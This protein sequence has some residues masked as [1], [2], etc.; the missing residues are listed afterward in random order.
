ML[1][2]G[3]LATDP[4]AAEDERAGREPAASLSA[5]EFHAARKIVDTPFG[6]I[7]YV[8]MGEGPVALFVHGALLNGYQWRHQLA[9][10]SDIRR[11]VAVDSMAMGYTEMAPGTPLGM[12]QQARMLA[13][14]LDALGIDQFDLVGNDSGGGA[15]QILAATHPQRIRSLTLTNCEVYG[16]DDQA[17]AFVQLR[18]QVASGALVAMLRA[19][20][21]N[22]ANGRAALSV[23]YQDP[24]ALSDDTIRTYFEP[25]VRSPERIEQVAGYL[26]AIDRGEL[27]ET[28][29]ALKALEAPVLVLW[30]TDDG[31]FDVER[32][33]WLK[34]NLRSVVDVVEIAGGRVFWPEEYPELLNEKLRALWT[35]SR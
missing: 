26:T 20:V 23:A 27:A 31:F 35:G 21:E 30:G 15:A 4:L 19:A 5:A 8:E 18:E 14:V 28:V 10:L 34:A 22:P 11:I 12:K 9:D 25:L 6:R 24:G 17:P 1:T 3:V 7:A 32:A 29:D 13:A 33:H 16:H 2:N